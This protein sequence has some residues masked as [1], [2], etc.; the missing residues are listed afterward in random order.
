MTIA[1]S[2][3]ERLMA[4]SR[5]LTSGVSANIHH[6]AGII[7]CAFSFR[8]SL[9]LSFF[10]FSS[11]H[12]GFAVLS[13]NDCAVEAVDGGVVLNTHAHYGVVLWRYGTF[14]YKPLFKE[15]ADMNCI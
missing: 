6:L 13:G 1:L 4:C 9:S 3:C 15:P 8:C 12:S 5:S 11:S 2:A 14:E 10:L 7:A